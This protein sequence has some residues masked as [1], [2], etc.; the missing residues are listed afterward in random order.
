MTE[1]QQPQQP[2]S[3]ETQ[4]APQQ[5]VPQPGQ[6]VQPVQP[7]Y[8]APQQPY[9]PQYAAPQQPYP[10]QQGYAAA[11]V[12]PGYPPQFPGLPPGSAVPTPPGGSNFSSGKGKT[13]GLIVAGVVAVGA[14]GGI[15]ALV[16]GG[17]DDEDKPSAGSDQNSGILDPKPVGSASPAPTEPAEP[18][19]PAEPT[20]PAEPT[21]TPE[22]EPEPEPPVDPPAGGGGLVTLP[23]NGL[24]VYVPPGW[25]AGDPGQF[26][27][28]M[29]DG[30]GAYAFVLTGQG[31]PSLESGSLIQQ[32]LDAMLPPSS[33][34]YELSNPQPANPSGSIVSVA[35]VDYDGTYV[36]SQSSLPVTG[37]IFGAVRSDGAG[38][39]ILI[40][41]GSIEDY[42]ASGEAFNALLN[43]TFALFGGS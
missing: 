16:F 28:Q 19:D 20:E 13:I 1:P 32:N 15:G 18:T 25:E 12:Q 31:D 4:M 30:E 36:D 2:T 17:G 11:P 27:V 43:E 40:E 35:S 29:I 37:R 42:N 41:H 33:Y 38:M 6:P 34:T 5:P 26:A 22:P 21:P 10:P 14:L 8:A 23:G 3:P 24:Q 39:L 7:G 9:P